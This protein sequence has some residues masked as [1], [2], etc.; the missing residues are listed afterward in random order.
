[1]ILKD[2]ERRTLSTQLFLHD[3]KMRSKVK[4]FPLSKNCVTMYVC[5][6]TVYDSPHIGNIRSAVIYDLLYRL[7]RA[8]H[9]NVKYVRNIT[10][11]D[12]K[13]IEEA[14]KKGINVTVL[15]REMEK[16]YQHD[17]RMVGCMNPTH[18]P[19]A[20]EHLAEIIDMIS[21]LLR[22]GH[23]YE[24]DKHILF[25]VRSYD[26][27]GMLSTRKMEDMMH[28]VR[29]DLGTYKKSPQD[30]ILWKPSGPEEV[31][32]DSPWGRGRPGWHIECSAMS[33]KYLGESF[34]IHGGGADLMFPH[35]E[36][37]I[38][39][40][41]CANKGSAFANI[42][43]HNGFLTVNGEK[44]SKSLGNFYLV[45]DIVGEDFHGLALR[46]MYLAA[47]YRKPMDY[48]DKA[49]FNANKELRKLADALFKICECLSKDAYLSLQNNLM[50]M[51]VETISADIEKMLCD[52][53]GKAMDVNE[54]DMIVQNE[55]KNEELYDVRGND[56]DNILRALANDLN[57]VEALR[58]L[59]DFAEDIIALSAECLEGAEDEFSD[60][61][62]KEELRVKAAYFMRS[63][64]LLGFGPESISDYMAKEM[65]KD[66]K[67][68]IV[69]DDVNRLARERAEAKNAKDWK[70]ADMLRDMIYE[71]GYIIEDEG[72]GKYR[73]ICAD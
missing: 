67:K 4:F 71:R 13:I 58:Y 7:L 57:S 32:Y 65:R 43:V 17:V 53:Y 11:I 5:G 2:I 60:A 63:C 15:A 33:C 23:A 62:I 18:E 24:S 39:Q 55:K 3:S 61:R 40:S 64:D 26:D 68:S 52:F 56:F 51:S 16:R 38:A 27:Y 21:E 73:I 50:S 70:K 69:P 72:G 45:K 49:A 1:M 44:M 42:W 30:F 66:Q 31:A 36:N 10:D 20:T 54:D 22:C 41:V 34:D 12:D 46:Y 8:L 25:D 14:K 48:N 47:H 6:P 28:G 37:E 59:R 35:H 9:K 19:R 29:I